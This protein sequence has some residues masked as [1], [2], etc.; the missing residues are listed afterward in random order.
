MCLT[1]FFVFTL[2][3]CVNFR[4][5]RYELTS[6][7]R[8]VDDK[9]HRVRLVLDDAIYLADSFEFTIY[10]LSLCYIESV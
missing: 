6:F 4:T 7:N 9:L 2:G 8:I 1:D 3:H 5:M 10:Q